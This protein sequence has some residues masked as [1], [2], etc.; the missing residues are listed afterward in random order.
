MNRRFYVHNDQI[1]A[2]HAEITGGEAHHL[3]TV[4]RLTPGE[5]I[6]LITSTSSMWAARIE[7]ISPKKIRLA[8]MQN[9]PAVRSSTSIVVAQA[10]LKA[11]KMDLLVRQ[12]TELGIAGFRPFFSSR[13]IPAP[14]A[15]KMKARRE[16]W[17]RISR[18]AAKQCGV[19]HL[20]DIYPAADFQTVLDQARSSDL[21]LIF[22]ESKAGEAVKPAGMES[23]AEPAT[24]FL[25]LGPEGGFTLDEIALAGEN[26]FQTAGLGPRVL[27]AETAAVAATVLAQ[28][29]W[30][31]WG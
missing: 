17:A 26:G 23:G 12:L 21:K 5:V 20:P 19:T 15:A 25:A 24:I 29:W 22:W 4:L 8:L 10:M 18:A 31:D 1:K 30:G 2:G 3:A 27:R 11:R 13:S 16:R 7:T 14:Q 9:I 28:H 6:T